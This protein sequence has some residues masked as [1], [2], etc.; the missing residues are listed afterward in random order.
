MIHTVLV[1]LVM[2]IEVT[3]ISL[4]FLKSG[5][6]SEEPGIAIRKLL[7]CKIF[8]PLVDWLKKDPS[9]DK[10]HQQ[11]QQIPFI[12]MIPTVYWYYSKLADNSAR[13]LD[14]AATVL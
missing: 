11:G 2:Q 10:C 6:L 13:Y 4:V 12:I 3:G 8:M 14:L 5:T 1:S 7:F 9:G